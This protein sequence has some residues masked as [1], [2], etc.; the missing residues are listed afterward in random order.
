MGR[1]RIG[2][3]QHFYFCFALLI[4]FAGCS[5]LRESNRR[6]EAREALAAGNELLNR[7]DFDASIRSYENVLAMAGEKPPADVATYQMALAYAHPKNP[8]RDLQKAMSSF[9]QVITA[10]PSSPWTEQARIWLGVLKETQASQREIE[11]SRREIEKSK[12]EIEKNRAAI[13]KSRQEIENSRAELEKT[14]HEIEKS[15]QVIEKSKQVDIEIDQKR[16]ERGR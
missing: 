13:E 7:G 16:R 10:Y 4:F 14:K 3:G 1:K 2:Q 9:S 5:L 12:E 6:R 8:K 15:R 11:E